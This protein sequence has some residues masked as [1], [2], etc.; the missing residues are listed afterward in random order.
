MMR[1]AKVY[2]HVTKQIY[3]PEITTCLTCGSRLR[4]STSIAQRTVVTLDGV[5]Q[6]VHCGYRCPMPD[7]A[8]AP[9]LYRSTVADGLALP[10]FTFGLDIVLLVGHLRLA[11]HQTVDEVH[12]T[13]NAR[14]TPFGTTV[15]RREILYLFDAYCTLLRASQSIADDHAW[16]EQTRTNGGVIISIDGIQPDKGSET[17][18]LVRDVVTGRLLAAENVR[19]SD[20]A[21]MTA[22][23]RPIR[24]LGVPV[25]GAVSDAQDS[26]LQ[27]IAVL[28]P[29]IPHQV[30]Q[31][32]Y[33]RE[34]SRPMYDVDRK[35]R[36]QIRKA[37]QQDVRMVRRQIDAH[38]AKLDPSDATDQ[39][40]TAHLQILDDYA[41]AAQTALNVDA[42][43]PFTYASPVVDDALDAISRSLAGLEKGAKRP[44]S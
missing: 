14:L 22:L 9:R 25:V 41:L 13:L 44:P 1:R 35:V 10:G 3:H 24:D 30:C 11:S 34:A 16:Q 38:T 33:L 4:R 20:T 26:L 19:I 2:P 32:H 15:S 5:L 23:L 31:F 27:S 39:R 43:Q 12:T 36:K 40:T 28:W 21:T 29:D 8:T 7:C 18:Y 17:I 37:L 42:L 6:V